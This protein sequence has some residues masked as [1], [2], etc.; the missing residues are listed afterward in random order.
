[1]FSCLSVYSRIAVCCFLF[2]S[3]FFSALK[4]LPIPHTH[5]H[6]SPHYLLVYTSNYVQWSD[7]SRRSDEHGKSRSKQKWEICLK[8]KSWSLFLSSALIWYEAL[9]APNQ[10]QDQLVY[11]WSNRKKSFGRSIITWVY[12]CV[13]LLY[14]YVQFLILLLAYIKQLTPFPNSVRLRFHVFLSQIWEKK[15]E[16]SSV[17]SVFGFRLFVLRWWSVFYQ[18]LSFTNK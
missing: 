3:F 13:W 8:Q 9:S 15:R 17:F 11:F 10:S 18:C 1:M 14:C 6:T 16:S 4:L 5:A 7:T 2:A 12:L